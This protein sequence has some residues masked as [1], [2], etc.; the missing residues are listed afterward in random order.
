MNIVTYLRVC[1]LCKGIVRSS[2]REGVV[3][4]STD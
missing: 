3:H 4:S 1:Y 2:G